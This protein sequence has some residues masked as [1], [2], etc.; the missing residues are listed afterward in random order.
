MIIMIRPT[1]CHHTC[2]CMEVIPITINL[3]LTIC[4]TTIRLIVICM[5][6]ML[7]PTSCHYTIFIEIVV[8]A[9]DFSLSI[10]LH[11]ACYRME[12]IP[13]IPILQPFIMHLAITV[14]VILLIRLT[15]LHRPA[16]CFHTIFIKIVPDIVYFL[17]S[18]NRLIIHIIHSSCLIPALFHLCFRN[19]SDFR[20]R[21]RFH[22]R[23]LRCINLIVIRSFRIRTYCCCICCI[24]SVCYSLSI[25]VQLLCFRL[26]CRCLFGL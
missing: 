26:N 25:C 4:H 18:H 15:C 11:N 22:R 21:S 19:R 2:N 9:I 3:F 24:H 5:I 16:C 10:H 20:I 7:C 1:G 6:V 12:V 13:C 23:C 14:I 8:T 17:F